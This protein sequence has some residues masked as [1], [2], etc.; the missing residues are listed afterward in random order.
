MGDDGIKDL[1]CQGQEIVVLR[2]LVLAPFVALESQE[3]GA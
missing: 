3:R 1:D 2:I